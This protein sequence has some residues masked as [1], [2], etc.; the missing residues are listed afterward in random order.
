MPD[1]ER[2]SGYGRVCVFLTRSFGI[3]ASL[4]VLVC[5]FISLIPIP[6]YLVGSIWRC[7][8]VGVLMIVTSVIMFFLEGSVMGHCVDRLSFLLIVNK[9]LRDWMRAV[10]YLGLACIPI[11]LFCL[12]ASTIIGLGLTFIVGAL[13][14]V[15]AI[16]Q[17]GE[18]TER[19]DRM[20]WSDL[21]GD[22]QASSG[23]E[24]SENVEKTK[25]QSA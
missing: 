4:V 16:G 19:Y 24:E 12:S 2:S 5:G 20:R 25:L 8:V 23:G 21:T 6:S 18:H 9:Y 14:F 3:F 13:N 7:F 10:L 22:G 15:L 17:K 1:S 11:A